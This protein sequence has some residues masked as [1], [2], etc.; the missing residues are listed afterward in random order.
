MF[1]TGCAIGQGNAC[2][3]FDPIYLDKQDRIVE[4]TARQVLTHN[5]K[6]QRL[7]KWQTVKGAR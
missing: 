6:G 5:E 1:T 2:K 7:C 4:S 3:T